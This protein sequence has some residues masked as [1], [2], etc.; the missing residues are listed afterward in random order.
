MINNPHPL[1]VHQDRQL[2]AEWPIPGS[3]NPGRICIT[4]ED[5]TPPRDTHQ[6]RLRLFRDKSG[7]VFPGKRKPSRETQ[8]ILNALSLAIAAVKKT[9]PDKVAALQA[10]P[11][12]LCLSL[13]YPWPK[14]APKWKR[15]RAEYKITRPDA[16]NLVKTIQDAI[17]IRGLIKDDNQ[18]A[19]LEVRKYHASLPGVFILIEPAVLL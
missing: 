7:R 19:N 6:S 4:F 9:D 16:D 8:E 1:K 14:S 12:R 10:G 15:D 13:F 11:V 3:L 2:P 5:I 18:V 17:A